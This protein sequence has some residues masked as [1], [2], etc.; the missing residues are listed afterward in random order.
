MESTGGNEVP[1]I[2][3]ALGIE[4]IVELIKSLDVNFDNHN[5]IIPIISVLNEDDLYAMELVIMLRGKYPSIRFSTTDSS[6]SLSSQIE[7]ALKINDSFII[8]VNQENMIGKTITVR[9]KENKL[10][11]IILTLD[12]LIDIMDKS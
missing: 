12:Q 1:A 8:I 7:N 9:M 4:R 2:G 6:A 10:N 11:D 5:T 3:F